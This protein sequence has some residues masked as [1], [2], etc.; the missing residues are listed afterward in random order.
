MKENWKQAICG[1]KE[2]L[3]FFETLQ[4]ARLALDEL[5]KYYRLGIQ[6][7]TDLIKNGS[8]LLIGNSSVKRSVSDYE[9]IKVVIGMLSDSLKIEL[10]TILI[11]Y[12]DSLYVSSLDLLV[13]NSLYIRDVSRYE[14][15]QNLLK[16]I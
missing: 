4:V 3:I 14:T 10:K 8:L 6:I 13:R 7:L 16:F 12:R 1:A 15:I 5:N 11:T 2:L 9:Y